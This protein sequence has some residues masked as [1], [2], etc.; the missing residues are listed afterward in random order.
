MTQSALSELGASIRRRGVPYGLSARARARLADVADGEGT[1]V[2][3]AEAL[4]WVRHAAVDDERTF[5]GCGFRI[6]DDGRRIDDDDDDGADSDEDLDGP[7][8]PAEGGVDSPLRAADYGGSRAARGAA[9][10]PRPPRPAAALSPPRSPPPHLSDILSADPT[11]FASG[12]PR[13]SPFQPNVGL[14]RAGAA[15]GR[16]LPA[17]PLAADTPADTP[18]T[19]PRHVPADIPPGSEPGDDAATWANLLLVRRVATRVRDV[20]ARRRALLPALQVRRGRPTARRARMPSPRA[21]AWGDRPTLQTAS[22][23]RAAP[24]LAPQAVSEALEAMWALV[25]PG[26]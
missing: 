15:R 18:M 26:I 11:L 5:E 13:V 2:T 12:A 22:D 14:L 6:G 7:E 23:L 8:P 25:L 16:R 20:T 17:S 1:G 10:L 9:T 19:R 3:R 4:R 24:C 21:P